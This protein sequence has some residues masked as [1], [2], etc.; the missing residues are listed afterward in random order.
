MWVDEGFLYALPAIILVLIGVGI[1]MDMFPILTSVLI[2]ATYLG[3]SIYLGV[4]DESWG[5]ALFPLIV[6]L[7][8]LLEKGIQY[9]LERYFNTKVDE[10]CLGCVLFMIVLTIAVWIGHLVCNN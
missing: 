3:I 6:G 1:F 9:I 5:M 2:I 7:T 4:K 8:I 10:G